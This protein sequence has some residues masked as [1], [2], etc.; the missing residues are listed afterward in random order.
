MQTL[1]LILQIILALGIYNVWLV[2][3]HRA[4]EYRGGGANSLRAE[5]TAYGLPVWMMYAVG[6]IKLLVATGLIVGIW[7]PMLIP[8]SAIVLGVMMLGA[9]FM[10]VKIK[11]SL[12]QTAPAIGML[13]MSL[14][15]I[16][17]VM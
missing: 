13:V 5:F 6:G 9:I 15:V 2:R 8:I 12:K 7:I 1:L 16:I 10:H 4:T 17:L 14:A 11:D 3:P